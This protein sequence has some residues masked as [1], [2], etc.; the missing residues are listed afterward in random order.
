MDSLRIQST[1]FANNKVM[2]TNAL[3][4]HGRANTDA[5]GANFAHFYGDPDKDDVLD[6]VLREDNSGDL[7]IGG[8]VKAPTGKCSS[9][10]QWVHSRDGHI[11]V[12]LSGVWIQKL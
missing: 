7:F 12:C 8:P 9:E 3:C 1:Y 6:F 5:G 4:R 2:S 11:S 10:G